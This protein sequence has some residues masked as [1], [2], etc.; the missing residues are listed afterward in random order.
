MRSILNHGE[1]QGNG[2]SRGSGCEAISTND[3]RI[4]DP[5]MGSGAN[6]VSFGEHCGAVDGIAWIHPGHR[7]DLIR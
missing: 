5:S 6:L 2:F 4:A 3:I 7:S 1:P